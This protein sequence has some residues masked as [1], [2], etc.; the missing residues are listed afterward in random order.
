MVGLL[1]G[2]DMLEVKRLETAI[3]R[4]G[5]RFLKRVYTNRE[6]DQIK[7]NLP[8]LAAR[9]AG[10]EAVAKAL[11]TGIGPVSWLEIEILRG[12]AREPVLHLFGEAKQLAEQRGITHWAIS[13]SHTHEHALAF[14][15]AS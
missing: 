12:P 9:F 15:V 10:K 3:L 2:V 7:G 11:A 1:T 6:L 5:D 14:V 8:S 4:H 13:L